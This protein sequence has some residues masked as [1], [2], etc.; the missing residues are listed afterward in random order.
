MTASNATRTSTPTDRTQ[1]MTARTQSFSYQPSLAVR[2]ARSL[3]KVERIA[4]PEKRYEAF[5]RHMREF[6]SVLTA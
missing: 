4:D 3:A 1:S 2:A 6:P 5:S